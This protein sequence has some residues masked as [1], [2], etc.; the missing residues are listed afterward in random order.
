[1]KLTKHWQQPHVIVAL[2]WQ[3]FHSEKELYL[4]V[5]CLQ[6]L[7]PKSS[8]LLLIYIFGVFFGKVVLTNTT[9]SCW[10]PLDDTRFHFD[11]LKI[12]NQRLLSEKKRNKVLWLHCR[13]QFYLMKKMC[14]FDFHFFP[15]ALLCSI[16]YH[17]NKCFGE[18]NSLL[19]S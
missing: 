15:K 2:F 6:W 16:S 17:K 8:L 14:V 3:Q 12:M 10:N 18:N 4:N 9:L 1:M 13:T 5:L 11:W 19:T 7:F